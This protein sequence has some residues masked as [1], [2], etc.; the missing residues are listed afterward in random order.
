MTERRASLHL[1]WALGALLFGFWT[2]MGA[3]GAGVCLVSGNLAGFVFG[4]AWTVGGYWFTRG[5][6]ER[7]RPTSPLPHL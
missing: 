3:L 2:L 5:M 6:V 7:A 4:L 1:G